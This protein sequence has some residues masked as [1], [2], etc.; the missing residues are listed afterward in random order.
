MPHSL[1]LVLDQP[2]G[3]FYTCEDVV[4]GKV[5]LEGSHLG[6]IGCVIVSFY[7]VVDT[8]AEIKG[9]SRAPQGGDASTRSVDKEV[10]F[11]LEK[12]LDQ[13]DGKGEDRINR[14]WPFQFGLEGSWGQGLSLPSSGKYH[15]SKVEYK[16]VAVLGK[17]GEDEDKVK[18]KIS[19][20]K[21]P[22]DFHET[23]FGFWARKQMGHVVERNIDLIESRSNS[24]VDDYIPP[25]SCW[26]LEIS[27]KHLPSF[28]SEREHKGIFHHQKIDMVP[29]NVNFEI[30]RTVV[31][32]APYLFN[33][34][35]SSEHLLW[36][37]PPPPIIL[38]E[39]K[40]DLR[41]ITI[42]RAVTS[43][44]ES[45]H[46]I[47][48]FYRRDLR[49]SLSSQP[50]DLGKVLPLLLSGR[51]VTS[52]FS[53]R[54]LERQYQLKTDVTLTVGDKTSNLKAAN[55][56]HIVL[57]PSLIVAARPKYIPPPSY[58]SEPSESS[59]R[60]R[61]EL[62]LHY[63]RLARISQVGSASLRPSSI[64]EAALTLS[65]LLTARGI[66]HSFPGGA[67]IKLHA[68]KPPGNQINDTDFDPRTDEQKILLVFR[69]EM[70]CPFRYAPK[71]DFAHSEQD[72]TFRYEEKPVGG[73][74]VIYD[75][76]LVFMPRKFRFPWKTFCYY[77]TKWR[78]LIIGCRK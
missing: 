39:M 67:T 70:N 54:L 29:F 63:H 33:L 8:V 17:E 6:S 5:I 65:R 53:T 51:E 50:L 31:E 21:K 44:A 56:H 7:G 37:H 73:K 18:L 38:T 62:H 16:V 58:P 12:R 3:G 75:L 76:R 19:P 46:D 61:K 52:T 20:R 59:A 32:G 11:Q 9:Q 28:P 24:F 43:R 49:I 23:D 2:P 4:S 64:L 69:E 74:D 78:W 68:Y 34:S 35:V 13:A 30:A 41:V 10:L 72:L 25:P 55:L 45:V 48:I 66:I 40:M 22:S 27:A 14:E 42:E 57:L 77:Y 71:D 15:Q 60:A 1:N 47:T 36:L 26:G